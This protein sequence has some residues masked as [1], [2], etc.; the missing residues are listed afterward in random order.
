MQKEPHPHKAPLHFPF[1]CQIKVFP[2]PPIVGHAT[3]FVLLLLLL[4]RVGALVVWLDKEIIV[5]W[6]EFELC[7]DPVALGT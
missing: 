7:C 6:L 2:P 4:L 3:T 1:S 5:I